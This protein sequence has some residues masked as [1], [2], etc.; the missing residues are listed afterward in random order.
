MRK[1]L[2][3]VGFCYLLGAAGPATPGS[4]NLIGTK[5]TILV[6]ATQ[7]NGTSVTIQDD[8][9]QGGGVPAHVHTREDET[10]VIT[11]GQFRFWRGHEIIDAGPGTVVYMPRNVPHQFRNVGATTGTVIFTITPAGLEK[12]FLTMSQRGLMWPKDQAAITTLTT[13]YGITN[14]PPLDQ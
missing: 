10:Y 3:A 2:V 14:L 7:T 9:P 1:I 8:V 13:Q 6:P 5:M 4:F 12:M 11:Q